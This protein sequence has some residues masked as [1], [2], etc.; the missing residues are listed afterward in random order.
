[1]TVEIPDVQWHSHSRSRYSYDEIVST[2]AEY[3]ACEREY[4]SL[5]RETPPIT[6]PYTKYL[7]GITYAPREIQ[8]LYAALDSS[9]IPPI[10]LGSGKENWPVATWRREIRAYR[11]LIRNLR[12]ALEACR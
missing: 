1:M 8:D 5:V 7:G 2:I 10:Q 6:D 3:E 9:D 4:M 11:R 12:I